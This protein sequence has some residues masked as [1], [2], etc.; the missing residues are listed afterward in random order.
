MRPKG[1]FHR[2]S[3]ALIAFGFL[4]SNVDTSMFYY[5]YGSSIIVALVYLWFNFASQSKFSLRELG[6]LY[7]FLGIDAKK[8]K[9]GLDLCQHKYIEQLLAKNCFNYVKGA[10][11]PMASSHII[12][13]YDGNPLDDSS[14]FRSTMGIL[15]H[16]LVTRP[17]IVYVVNK[18]CQ[19]LHASTG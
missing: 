9:E 5:F 7:F 16:C 10:K 1:M 18:L 4:N 14:M 12:S 3:S 6:P 2:F 11:T 15:Q 8:I 19:F 17:E 13:C